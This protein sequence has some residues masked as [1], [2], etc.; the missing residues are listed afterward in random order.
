[1]A[2]R[3]ERPCTVEILNYRRDGT[4]FWN[5]LSITPVRDDDGTVSHFIGIQSD[6]TSR[7][8]AEDSLRSVSAELAKANSKMRRDLDVAARIQRSLLPVEIPAIPG[9][10]VHW[11]FVPCDELAGDTL[12][13]IPL[14]RNQLAVFVIDVSGHG[15]PAALL[16][17][18]L[19]HWL[20]GG[21]SGSRLLRE[22][23]SVR[24]PAAVLDELNQQFQMDPTIAQYFTMFY[25]AI[26][27]SVGELVYASAGHPPALLVAADGHTERLNAT[28]VPVGVVSSGAYRQNRL[29][30]AP[31]ERLFIYTDGLIEAEDT[32]GRPVGVEGVEA[33]ATE[34]AA[35]PLA[36]AVD[37]IMARYGGGSAE[38]ATDDLTLLAI[39]RVTRS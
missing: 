31:G 36:E 15:V 24:S 25:A 14:G 9:L 20:S 13:L 5:R 35:S 38:Q 12:G 21:P 29:W 16:S 22:D 28:G 33:R 30:L 1:M 6:I 11:R 2:L 3:E 19:T 23:G 34:T 18:T 7:K 26:D 32:H 4:P 8:Q 27:M 10:N 17:V 39:E 37:A